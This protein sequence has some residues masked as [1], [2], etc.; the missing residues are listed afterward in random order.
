MVC[1][2]SESLINGY[3]CEREES[4][5]MLIRDMNLF[6]LSHSHFRF[7][8]QTDAATSHDNLMKINF[9]EV[10]MASENEEKTPRG[11]FLGVADS[12]VYKLT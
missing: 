4:K 8:L 5:I 2:S 9:L 7:V 3:M 10:M 1:D 12:H 6:S 11:G